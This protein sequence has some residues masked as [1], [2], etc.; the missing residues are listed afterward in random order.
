MELLQLLGSSFDCSC[1]KSHMVPTEKLV[2]TE[3]AFSSI[4]G[5]IDTYSPDRSCLIIADRR[6]Y[7]VAGTEIADLCKAGGI[8]CSHFIV[9]S[10]VEL[11]RFTLNSIDYNPPG[12]RPQ[13]HTK[14]GRKI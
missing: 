2:Y 6:T 11:N 5:L 12:C 13:F 4:N 3:D 9:A 1:G 10:A 8:R 14:T 7:G